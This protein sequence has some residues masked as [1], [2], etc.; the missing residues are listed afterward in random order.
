MEKYFLQKTPLTIPAEQ[1]KI[2][3]EHFGRLASAENTISIA[4]MTAPPGWYEQSQLP[5][6]DEYI[7]MQKGRLLLEFED[8]EIVIKAGQSVHVVKRNLVRYSNPYRDEAVYWSV[9]LPAFSPDLT[10][11]NP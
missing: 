5:E 2:I 6:F 4:A 1:N 11:R 10:G 3:L 8:E 7:L 9:C